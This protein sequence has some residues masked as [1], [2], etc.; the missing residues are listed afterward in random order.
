MRY[1][2]ILFIVF[3]TSCNW[4]KEKA[5]ETVNKSGE[6]VGKAGSEFADGVA[7]GVEKT[8]QNEIRFSDQLSKKG[9]KAGKVIINGTDSTADNILTAYL[10]FDDNI[11]QKITVKVFTGDGLEYGRTTQDIHGQKGEARYIDFVF[12]KRTNLDGRSTISFE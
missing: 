12:D 3:A 5:K 8:F 6:T 11:N 2:L 9:L 10:I 4:A 7:K 1:L